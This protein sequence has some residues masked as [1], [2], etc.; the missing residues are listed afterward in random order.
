MA[1]PVKRMHYFDYQFLRARDFIDEQNYFLAMRRQHNR[2]LHS[3]G[4]TTG[5]EVSANS[6]ANTV[7]ISPGLAIDSQGREIVLAAAAQSPDLRKYAGQTVFATIAYGEQESDA[8]TETGTPGNTRITEMAVIDIVTT[9]PA[10]PSLTLILARIAVK[11]DGSMDVDNGVEPNR[12]HYAS[13]AAGDLAAHSVTLAPPNVPRDQWRHITLSPGDNPSVTID[14]PLGVGVDLQG[15]YGPMLDVAG[16]VRIRSY[17]DG[18]DT[19]FRTGLVFSHDTSGSTVD[20]AFFILTDRNTLALGDD[21]AGG[22]GWG[23]LLDLNTR[24]VTFPNAITAAGTVFPSDER[25]K[26]SVAPI[27][28]PLDKV[29]RIRG[30]TYQSAADCSKPREVGV[31]AQEVEQVMPEIVAE[32]GSGMK[33]VDYAR[34]TALLIEA[35]KE[36]REKVDD[37]TH[38]IGELQAAR[39]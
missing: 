11:S 24:K 12:R 25:L 22:T 36:L 15:G 39:P 16:R 29:S 34:L 26:T 33:G 30:V 28:E 17:R 31:I 21:I 7:T 13:A 23:L 6:G 9:P 18:S 20:K 8:T 5:L 2:T 4:V 1:D 38:R 3:W 19:A 14:A 32:C 35:V 37:L 10:D 27:A